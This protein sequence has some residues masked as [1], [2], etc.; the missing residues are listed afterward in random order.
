[1]KERREQGPSINDRI[2]AAQ[3]QLIGS[4]GA[5]VGIVSRDD[6]LHMAEEEGLDLVLLAESGSEG[7][8]VAKIMDFGKTLYEKKKKQSEAKKHQKIIQIKEVKMRPKIGDHDYE[9]KMK[10]AIQF[11]KSGKRVKFTL[12]FRGRENITR[13]ERGN[14]IFKKIDET[15]QKYDLRK[16]LVQ[17][18]DTKMGQFWSRI[19]YLKTNK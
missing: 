6:A 15:L 7:V 14:E 3:L 17:E 12:S 18:K 19:Y 9:T 10:Q 11:L 5:Y 4:D 16:N 8:P 13:E 1:M 2:R